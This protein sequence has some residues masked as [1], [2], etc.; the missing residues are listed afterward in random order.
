MESE[1][2]QA[3]DG[4]KYRMTIVRGSD[5]QYHLTFVPMNKYNNRTE[6]IVCTDMTDAMDKFEMNKRFYTGKGL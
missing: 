2:I 3:L 6:D 1:V 4:N 5:D